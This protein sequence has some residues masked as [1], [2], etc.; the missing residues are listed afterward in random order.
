[1][2]QRINVIKFIILLLFCIQ[3]T[4]TA[5]ADETE[6]VIGTGAEL[7]EQA[8]TEPGLEGQT[9]TEPDLKAPI[10][11]KESINPKTGIEDSTEID[12]KPEDPAV[13]E[14]EV[15]DETHYGWYLENKDWYYYSPESGI[16]L[17]GWQLVDDVWYYLDADNQQKPGVML[18]NQIKI[19][20]NS[21]Y[22][23]SDSGAMQTGWVLRPEG[24]Y[25][26][27]SSGA[28]QTGWLSLD[29][30]WYYLDTYHQT[31]P[32]LMVSD[33]KKSIN[34]NT[35]FFTDSGAMQTGWVQSPEGWYFTDSNGAIQIGWILKGGTWYY[36]DADNQ[37]YPGLMVS[38][39]KRA[40]NGNTYFFTDSGAMQTG[41]VQSPEGWYFTNSDGALNTGWILLGRTWYYLDGN[42][43]TYPGLMV[44]NC[45]RQIGGLTYYFNSDGSMR[46]GWHK[47]NSEWYYYDDTSGQITTGWRLVDGYWYYLDNSG[48]M[49][50]G[51]KFIDGYWYYLSSSGA[52]LTGPQMIDGT[53]YY[54]NKDSGAWAEIDL[55]RIIRNAKLPLG[56]TL[57]VWG[58]GW[59]IADNAA[60]EAALHDGVWPEWETYFNAN[61]NGY[62]YRPGQTSWKNGNRQW[63]L[64]GLDC[65]G[66]LGWLIYN[67]V[68]GGRNSSGYVVNATSFA[69]SLANYGF[70]NVAS[71]TP[72][73]SF[74]P[75]DIVSIPNGHCF[76]VLGQ[77]SDGSVLL[78]HS[79]PNGG[80]QVSGTV[81]GSGSSVASR[82]AQQY[83]QQYYPNWWRA[84]GN[85]NRQKVNANSYLTGTKFSWQLNGS[86]RD[87][88]GILN[89]TGEQIL[90]YLK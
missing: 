68:S 29:N 26:A 66:Y 21:T 63:R 86:V 45:Q 14:T 32:G 27:G 37:S 28:M 83:M 55:A 78:L 47:D 53:K 11:M 6:D 3:L 33:N 69:S 43:Q 65:S 2:K 30:T 4:M 59:N 10:T 77:C 81:T 22:F 18:S 35:Y 79:T 75:G 31:Y 88:T 74:R 49:V 16:K 20:N 56:R 48:K 73:S 38:N 1:M 15:E 39:S 64:K 80:V 61:K 54:L 41:W 60:G 72:S 7:N 62:S 46:T 84:F 58:G 36:L 42:N 24:W 85:E 89:K 82:L 57:Y 87:S 52:M 25:F 90:E 23:F 67:S 70:G 76:L 50:T 51:W 13:L 19:I 17:T 34:G 8:D 40:I 5:Y 9:N 44:A 71:C 12:T